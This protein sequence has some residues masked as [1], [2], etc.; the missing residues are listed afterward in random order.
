MA[1]PRINKDLRD[2]AVAKAAKSVF[3][4]DYTLLESMKTG[5]ADKLYDRA[6]GEAEKQAKKLPTCWFNS[7]D[8]V[9]IS[10]AGFAHHRYSCDAD[11]YLSC[12]LKLSKERLAPANKGIAF[13]INEDDAL[14]VEAHF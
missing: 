3:S 9:Y 8:S 12:A 7:L 1:S 2:K 6:F 11:E 10:C 13:K 4:A 5:L 14:Y